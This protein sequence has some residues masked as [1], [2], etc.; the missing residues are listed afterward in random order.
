MWASFPCH[1]KLKLNYKAYIT[2]N[3]SEKEFDRVMERYL[4]ANAEYRKCSSALE[5]CLLQPKHLTIPSEVKSKSKSVP[6]STQSKL[7]ELKKDIEMR[8]L[9]LK[10]KQ[11]RSQYELEMERQ[12]IELEIK[13]KIKACE[14][15]FKIE[16]AEKE[17][18]LLE[19]Y[20]SEAGSSHGLEVLLGHKCP[21]R[22][23]ID[24]WSAG[25]DGNSLNLEAADF[26]PERYSILTSQERYESYLTQLQSMEELLLTATFCKDPIVLSLEFY[27]GFDRTILRL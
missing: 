16:K 7:N 27:W 22:K 18:E 19:Q 11:E 10:Q 23:K 9:I 12:K 8:K 1:S 15:K 14:M 25:L 4:E 20:G 21:K 2:N 24:R 3:L 5:V 13:N 6:S 17:A 26:V